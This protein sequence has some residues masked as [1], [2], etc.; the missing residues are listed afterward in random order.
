MPI[1]NTSSTNSVRIL[2][3]IEKNGE[4]GGDGQK[5]GGGDKRGKGRYNGYKN[6]I[7]ST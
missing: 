3:G 5:Y 6:K 2:D 4:K 1:Q 7:Y